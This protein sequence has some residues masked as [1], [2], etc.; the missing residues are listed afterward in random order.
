LSNPVLTY[1]GWSIKDYA[2]AWHDGQFY[3]FFSAFYEDAGRVRSHVVEV[4]TPDFVH[5]SEP[6]L[7][8]EGMDRGWIGACSPDI[9]FHKG[10]YYLT[11]NS[12]GNKEGAPNQLFYRTSP[13]LRHWSEVKPLADNL[14]QGSGPID[15][16]LA[17]TEN[18][19]YVAWSQHRKTRIATAGDIDG[20]FHYP[21]GYD[22]FAELLMEDGKPL[23]KHQENASFHKIGGKW[24]LLVNGYEPHRPTL[25][26]MKGSGG[27][28][29]DWLHWVDGFEME[30]P[31]EKFNLPYQG[32]P[33]Y[34]YHRSNASFL[35]D[36]R[37][38]DGYWYCLYAGRDGYR[39]KVEN[40]P[41]DGRGWNRLGLARSRDLRNW[42][43]AGEF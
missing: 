14:T 8:F 22:G 11:F 43:P 35:L 12:W 32:D 42:K 13:D 34:D 37:H 7:H 19:V 20:E 39:K 31:R 36:L 30:M 5:Y 41:F 27:R 3:L 21:A 24:H 28:E 29:A 10:L 17:F 15:A 25:F 18:R 6:I 26:R 40:R 4:S 38:L 33:D 1:P 9:T 16:A 2:C 23:K